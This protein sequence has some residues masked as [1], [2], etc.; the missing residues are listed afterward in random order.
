MNQAIKEI[1]IKHNIG[2]NHWQQIKFQNA[3]IEI[4]EEQI[5]QCVLEFGADS[6][7][8]EQILNSKNI[9]G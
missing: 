7:S 5:K 6:I 2:L 4:C 9:A 1:L 3:I 8:E